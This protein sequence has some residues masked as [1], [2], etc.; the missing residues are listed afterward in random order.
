VNIPKELRDKYKIEEEDRVLYVDVR[1][2]ISLLP[3]PKNPL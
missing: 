3:V 2:H 1:D